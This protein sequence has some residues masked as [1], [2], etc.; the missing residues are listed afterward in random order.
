MFDFFL[1][2]IGVTASIG[3]QITNSEAIAALGGVT[4]ARVLRLLRLTYGLRAVEWGV[5]FYKLATGLMNSVR[6]IVSAFVL[7][8]GAMYLFAC[9][10]VEICNSEKLQAHPETAD[11]V[12][13]HFGSVFKALL[14]FS[15]F[16]N[17]DSI[18]AIY[19]P[20]IRVEPWLAVYFML[21]ILV[22]AVSLMNLVT[23]LIVDSAIRAAS[24]DKEALDEEKKRT[25]EDLLPEI[26]DAF[27]MMDSDGNGDLRHE[28]LNSDEILE[29]LPDGLKEVIPADKLAEIF[30]TLGDTLEDSMGGTINELEFTWAVVTVAVGG[31]EYKQMMSYLRTI[32]NQLKTITKDHAALMKRL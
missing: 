5:D 11:I 32:A 12:D 16:I 23:A 24:S 15:Q 8:F 29:Y 31:I 25:I 9:V 2:L 28:E 27:R 17:A 13:V 14:T 10:G 6:T 18:A 19:N 4:I 7:I 26:H 20:L 22:I 21:G 1:I 30:D 3:S